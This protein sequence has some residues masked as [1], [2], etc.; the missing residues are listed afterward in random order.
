MN[1]FWG[2]TLSAAV[3]TVAAGTAI[4][5]CAHNDAS[6]FVHGVLLPPTPNGNA[7]IYTADPTAAL[8][9]HGVVDGALTDNYSP[10]FLVGSTLIPKG[11]L[12]TP[13]SETARVEIQ[14]TIIKVIDPVDNSVWENNSVLTA[15]ILDPASGTAPAYSAIQASIMDAAAV[16]HFTPPPPPTGQA[17]TSKLAVVDVTFYGVTLGGQSVQSDVFEFPVDVC[18][19]CLVSVPAG[20]VTGY[21]KGAV[22]STSTALACQIGQD[23]AV[24]CQKCY[25]NPLSTV[26]DSP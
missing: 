1:R 2:H 10:E 19:G 24:D 25:G 20:A 8:I 9:N 4:P 17:S 7:C 13:D 16:A 11:N 26:C 5:A 6:I 21:C 23:Q 12:A 14:G 3:L 18:Y 15:G 22:P